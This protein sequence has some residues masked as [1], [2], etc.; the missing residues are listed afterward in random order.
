MNV[1]YFI[2]KN[3]LRFANFEPLLMLIE[4]EGNLCRGKK[5][6]QNLLFGYILWRIFN[7]HGNWLLRE[8]SKNLNANN[9]WCIYG[10]SRIHKQ[11]TRAIYASHFQKQKLLRA[12]PPTE[13][14][15]TSQEAPISCDVDRLDTAFHSSFDPFPSLCRCSKVNAFVGCALMSKV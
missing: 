10:W 5:H 4:K 15:F 3:N 6:W 13:V 1:A 8:T 9:F 12:Q 11:N 14:Q 2:A 7:I